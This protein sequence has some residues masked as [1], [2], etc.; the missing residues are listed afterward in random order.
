VNRAANLVFTWTGGGGG[1]GTASVSLTSVRGLQDPV[2]GAICRFPIADGT[3]TVTA[4][5]L[6]NLPKS[7]GVISVTATSNKSVVADQA[8]IELTV[9]SS[10]PGP[11]GNATGQ[12]NFN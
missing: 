9:R 10:V 3:G 6:G 11:S 12:A 7:S 5:V 8:T 4:N 2:I 1:T